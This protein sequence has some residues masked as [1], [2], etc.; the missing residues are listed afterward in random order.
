MLHLLSPRFNFLTRHTRTVS[1]DRLN[2]VCQTCFSPGLR[3]TDAL[4]RITLLLVAMLMMVV[5]AEARGSRTEHPGSSASFSR[6]QSSTRHSTHS[7]SPRRSHHSY[8]TRA[9]KSSR[10]SS[11][12][13]VRDS[14]GRI[15][16]SA[17]AKDAFKRQQ[18][19]PSTGKSRGA[20]PGYV[21]DHVKPL[22]C[23]GADAPSNMQ[24]QTVAAGKAKDK[25]ERN[26]R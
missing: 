20:C 16:R 24:W 12:R 5:S 21:I 7:Y 22:E 2:S 14:H 6:S 11:S 13:T 9:H 26:C 10:A 1:L 23:G 4:M 25:T 15:K 17:A 3:L 18:P 19:C 8:G